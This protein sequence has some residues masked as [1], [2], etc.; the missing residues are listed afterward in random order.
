[1]EPA[2]PPF[3]T[4]SLVDEDP[5]L[6]EEGTL[7][8]IPLRRRLGV[9]AFGTNAFRA[10]RVGDPVVE[11]HVESPGQEELYV[12][13]T[14]RAR[15]SIDGEETDVTTGTAVFVP[16]PDVRRSAVALEDQTIVLAVGGW[17]GRPYHSLPWEPIYMA[18]E[19]M[20]HG[21]W[22]AAA[23]ILERE[24]GEHLGTAIVQFRLA[25]CHAQLG[26]TELALEEVRRAVE[27]NPS[28]RDR[29]ATDELLAPLREHEGWPGD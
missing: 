26:E 28:I 17:S 1:V 16:N 14:G 11:D 20:R 15:F 7:A 23:E 12:V 22:A 2:E 8:W 21:D 4:L 3:R 25:C 29:L 27:L 6:T 18:Q 19:P 10:A 24:A 9:T 13:V 5:V